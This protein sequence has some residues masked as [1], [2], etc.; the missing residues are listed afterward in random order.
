MNTIAQAADEAHSDIA[1]D[2][3]ARKQRQIRIIKIAI[4][5]LYFVLVAG[6][7]YLT[8]KHP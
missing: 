4:G 1:G 5:V 6:A 8:V 2:K 7:A 3:A